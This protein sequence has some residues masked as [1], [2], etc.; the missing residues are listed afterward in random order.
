MCS[1]PGPNNHLE[2]HADNWDPACHP[3][4]LRTSS[5]TSPLSAYSP[6]LASR[7]QALCISSVLVD[8]L[9]LHWIHKICPCSFSWR[10]DDI[11]VPSRTPG[12]I[13]GWLLNNEHLQEFPLFQLELKPGQAP[14]FYPLSLQ[15]IWSHSSSHKTHGR[16]WIEG[17]EVF[18]LPTAS[19][20]RP[21]M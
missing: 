6:G 12:T 16:A 19:K 4:A 11:L 3:R 2:F 21:Q 8:Q 14:P 20:L 5:G 18:A 10:T 13:S 9:L 7:Q 17:N 1:F 15:C